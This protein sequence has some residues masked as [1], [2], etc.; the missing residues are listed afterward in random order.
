MRYI[1]VIAFAMVPLLLGCGIFVLLL[2]N[3]IEAL[4]QETA[5][6][7][8]PG[9][10]EFQIDEP[11]RYH[12]WLHQQ[13]VYQGDAYQTQR[14]PA[15]ANTEIL[16]V[17]TAIPIE[18]AVGSTTKSTGSDDA[19]SLGTFQAI[20]TGSYV[21]AASGN[22]E[23]ILSVSQFDFLS[24]MGSGFG[25]MAALLLGLAACAVILVV[26]ITRGKRKRLPLSSQRVVD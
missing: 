22:D 21:V 20:E 8:F 2:L 25:A 19:I 26:G 18:T 14:L 23:Y 13:T 24:M 3:F 4:S 12:V 5:R 1:K 17:Q 15:D 6:G 9:Q 10:L 7:R 16:F 11:G